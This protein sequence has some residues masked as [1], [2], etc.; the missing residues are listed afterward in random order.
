MG[1]LALT[2]LMYVIAAVIVLWTAGA[3]F[4]DAG[5]AS[6]VGAIIA[7]AWVALATAALILWQ[8]TWKPFAVL[9]LVDSAI[10]WWWWSQKP[11][12]DRHWDP[13]FFAPRKDGP[14]NPDRVVAAARS[15]TLPVL[16][17]RGRASDVVTEEQVREFLELIPH[18]SYVDVERARHMV[19]GDRN[20]IF[21]EAV[22]DFLAQLPPYESQ[23]N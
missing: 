13:N 12:H 2:Y 6:M 10:I 4:Y 3:L 5:G 8:P 15:I 16:L 9:L 18:A 7:V 14:Q 20:D 19:A 17:I 11:S 21:T 23:N 1:W 22:V